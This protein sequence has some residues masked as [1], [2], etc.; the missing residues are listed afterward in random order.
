MLEPGMS[1]D[2][3]LVIDKS[4]SFAT[5]ARRFKLMENAMA[6][7]ATTSPFNSSQT[8]SRQ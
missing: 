2:F 6:S 1:I 5:Q 7:R 8:W 4:T 3:S